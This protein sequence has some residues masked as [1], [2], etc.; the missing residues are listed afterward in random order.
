MPKPL[1]V[2]WLFR[3]FNCIVTFLFTGIALDMARVFGFDLIFFCY[4]DSIDSGSWMT[5]SLFSLTL[6][7]AEGLDLRLISRRKRV[8]GLNLFFVPVGSL[9]LLPLIGI[10]LVFL[11]QR[12]VFFWVPRIDLLCPEGWLKACFCFCIDSFSYHLVL[13]IQVPPSII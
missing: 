13:H 11:D 6:F 3:V 8:V 5:F 4:L 2:F 9:Y 12:L 10:V 1:L 7:E